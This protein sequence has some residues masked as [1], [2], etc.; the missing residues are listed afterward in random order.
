MNFQTKFFFSILFT[1]LIACKNDQQHV[2]TE[3]AED[4]MQGIIEYSAGEV[5]EEFNEK[6]VPSF[7]NIASLEILPEIHNVIIP[8]NKIKKGKKV[9]FKPIA[10]LSFHRDSVLHEFIIANTIDK[11]IS[12]IKSETNLDFMVK[13]RDFQLLLENWFKINCNLGQCRDFSWG[14][15]LQVKSIINKHLKAKS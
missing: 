4:G 5:F 12:V 2:I 9:S 6:G 8:S 11:D 15:E 7:F 10:L 3:L 13:H 14:S 1:L